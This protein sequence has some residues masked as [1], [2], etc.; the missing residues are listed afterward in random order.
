MIYRRR[1]PHDK[2]VELQ[3][4]RG[5][6]YCKQ[7]SANNTEAI[8][9]FAVGASSPTICEFIAAGCYMSSPIQGHISHRILMHI[10]L[11]QVGLLAFSYLYPN[12]LFIQGD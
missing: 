6:V 9:P 3:R 1:I 2:Q 12:W 11:F 5:H 4:G 10:D 8:C 7:D